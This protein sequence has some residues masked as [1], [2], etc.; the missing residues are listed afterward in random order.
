MNKYETV[1]REMQV[2]HCKSDNEGCI[3]PNGNR[4]ALQGFARQWKALFSFFL[5]VL[6]FVSGI[7]HAYAEETHFRLPKPEP[8]MYSIKNKVPNAEY[9][10]VVVLN[11]RDN[12]DDHAIVVLRADGT[13]VVHDPNS[14]FNKYQLE[15]F[16]K[17]NDIVQIETNGIEILGLRQDGSVVCEKVLYP[18]LN[19]SYV[20]PPRNWT[21]VALLTHDFPGHIFALTRSG[22]IFLWG[23]MC[24]FKK[25]VDRY[26]ELQ[27]IRAIIP[28]SYPESTG[29][30]GLLE[31]GRL[32]TVNDLF[33][34]YRFRREPRKTVQISSSG[35]ITACLDSDG[36]LSASGM[37]ADN[38]LLDELETLDP[39]KQ[40][41]AYDKFIVCLMADGH[42]KQICAHRFSETEKGFPTAES[43]HDV[44]A[45]Y[46][47]GPILI[48]L[49]EDG[50]VTIDRSSSLNNPEHLDEICKSLS[51]WND[52]VEIKVY[53]DYVLGWQKDGTLLTAGIDL[54]WLP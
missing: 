46:S 6:I 36:R 30:I 9:A 18:G 12:D 39:V 51:T 25:D 40:A 35:Y 48:G 17:W 50:H 23:D 44:K 53:R 20:L 15:S 7:S 10:D 13:L 26:P 45:L 2:I 4:K 11:A 27:N 22:H 52:V 5:S 32:L 33:S 24:L 3:V 14:I 34:V 43:W 49:Y 1:C 42:V 19:E 54:S 47:N 31:D 16:S 21:N 29:I 8:G 28:Y 37:Y 38:G 41:L